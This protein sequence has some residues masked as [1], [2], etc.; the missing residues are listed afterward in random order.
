MNLA[1]ATY[2][3]TGVSFAVILTLV[4]FYV[5]PAVQKMPLAQSLTLFLWPNAFRFVA[6]EI[7]PETASGGVTAPPEVMAQIALGD[8]LSGLLAFAAIWA[9]RFRARYALLVTWIAVVFGTL[10][11]ANG[12]VTSLSVNLA[13]NVSGVSWMLLFLFFPLVII[14]SAMLFWQLVSRRSEGL[15]DRDRATVLA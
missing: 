12:L 5:V 2:A 13:G 7:I 10:D 4:F 1:L 9:I 3:A 8:T 6:L 11:I 14:S 15:N